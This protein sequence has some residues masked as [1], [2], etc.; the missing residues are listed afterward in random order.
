MGLVYLYLT[1]FVCLQALVT[2]LVRYEVSFSAASIGMVIINNTLSWST[3]IDNILPKLSSACY[4]MRS[5]KSYVSRQML[6]VIY[7]SYFHSIMSY[8]IIFWGHSVGGM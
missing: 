4:A 7:Y 2:L 5:V 6:K 3:H 1:L 8:G